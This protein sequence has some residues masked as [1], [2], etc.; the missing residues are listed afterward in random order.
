LP[1]ANAR[2]HP[3]SLWRAN[4]VQGRLSRSSLICCSTAR[5]IG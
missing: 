1:S 3:H 5:R 4:V 2:A